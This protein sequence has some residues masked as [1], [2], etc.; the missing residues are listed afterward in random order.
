MPNSS[1]SDNLSQ[2]PDIGPE[3]LIIELDK[4]ILDDTLTDEDI[5]YSYSLY[6]SFS[7]SITDDVQSYDR[8]TML[9]LAG[10][11]YL[12]YGEQEKAEEM[13]DESLSYLDP[14]SNLYSS[15]A[16]SWLTNKK[17]VKLKYRRRTLR[18]V[19]IR[20]VI[21]FVVIF[22]AFG[23]WTDSDSGVLA[24]ADKAMIEM[25][26]D[27]GMSQRG[28]VAFLRA[29]PEIIN[30]AT[31]DSACDAVE[32]GTSVELGCYDP[33]I[34]KIYIRDLPTELNS[35]ELVTAAHEMLHAVADADGISENVSTD[36]TAQM[37]AL[38][39]DVQFQNAMSGY[40]DLSDTIKFR[41]AQAIIGTEVRELPDALLTY[42]STYFDHRGTV[43]E[44]NEAIVT[45]FKQKE[46]QLIHIS[47]EIDVLKSNANIYYNNHSYAARNGNSYNYNYYWNLY[48]TTYDQSTELINQY[49]SELEAYNTLAEG[50]NG[51]P[52]VPITLDAQP[53]L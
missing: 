11:L 2:H 16:S 45:L 47:N 19:V 10:L 34:N 7:D 35:M 1:L 31:M 42:Y 39:G 40:A 21:G 15:F 13:L 48:R 12:M 14:R 25:A 41:E 46:D 26:D 29:E 32:S 43:L 33:N 22:F 23:L 37:A 20:T 52:F 17:K 36:I 27:A 30:S 5:D 51:K 44:A 4:T 38:A 9:E 6:L 24:L 8:A 49:N 53:Q 3:L 18:K 50:Y 28:K